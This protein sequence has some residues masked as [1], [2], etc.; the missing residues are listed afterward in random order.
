MEAQ[1]PNNGITASGHALHTLIPSCRAIQG[2]RLWYAAVASHLSCMAYAA[3]YLPPLC[4]QCT[5]FIC[6]RWH[7]TVMRRPSICR[8]IVAPPTATAATATT[9]TTAAAAASNGLLGIPGTVVEA[10]RVAAAAAPSA[11]RALQQHHHRQR[12]IHWRWCVVTC[13]TANGTRSSSSKC[14]C[15]RSTLLSP[16]SPSA[17]AL[18]P[19]ALWHPRATGTLPPKAA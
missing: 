6:W 14:R 19:Y 18:P 2:K 15:R 17:P 5:L 9:T 1:L 16:W 11:F 3:I 13:A 10:L 12:V 8:G 7:G 4:I